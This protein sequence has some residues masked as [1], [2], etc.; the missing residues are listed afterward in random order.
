MLVVDVADDKCTGASAVYQ[1]VILNT[2]AVRAGQED[3]KAIE[4]VIDI[5]WQEVVD[6]VKIYHYLI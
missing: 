2:A 3:V 1:C 6:Y 5:D 4:L